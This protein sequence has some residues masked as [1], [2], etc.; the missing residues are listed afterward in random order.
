MRIIGNVEVVLP[1]LPVG[2]TRFSVEAYNNFLFDQM[3]G[4]FVGVGLYSRNSAAGLVILFG[5][6]EGNEQQ[7]EKYN[8]NE[9]THR[10]SPL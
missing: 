8:N 5:R 10:K 2:L 3:A 1:R 9:F 4:K 7:K 6:K